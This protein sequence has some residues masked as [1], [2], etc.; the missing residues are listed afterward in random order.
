MVY[1]TSLRHPRPDTADTLLGRRE[2]QNVP[3]RCSNLSNHCK[4]FLITEEFDDALDLSSRQTGTTRDIGDGRPR[5]S[6]VF[7]PII[8]KRVK[9]T[10]LCGS[11]P[12][13]GGC[14]R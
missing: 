6:L 9:D 5:A 7:I 1:M 14:M 12:F 11:K 3:V 4:Q 13:T 8:R 2:N 10:F